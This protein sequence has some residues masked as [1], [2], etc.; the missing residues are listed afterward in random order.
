MTG[1]VGAANE[2][3]N[4]VKHMY[5]RAVTEG[6]PNAPVPELIALLAGEAPKAG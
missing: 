5:E 3:A 2:A 4:A 6:G 1:E